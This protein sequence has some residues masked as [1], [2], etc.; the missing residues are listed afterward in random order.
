MTDKTLR[1]GF[2]AAGLMNI[3]P[4]LVLSR[5][6][7]NEV[8]PETDPAVMSNFGLLMIM[9]WGLAY[10]ALAVNY[11]KAK[12]VVGVFVVEKLIYVIAWLMWIVNNDV[13]KVYKKDLF[14]GL[15]YSVYGINDLIFFL[16][17]LFVFY[18]I[19]FKST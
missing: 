7:T 10:I 14:A 18:R 1:N 11:S 6:F 17:F 2:I 8:I 4:V 5:F 9:V 19:Q 12:W 13:S 15:F 3:I 16:F